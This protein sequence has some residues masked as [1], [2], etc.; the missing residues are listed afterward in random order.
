MCWTINLVSLLVLLGSFTTERVLSSLALTRSN[1]RNAGSAGMLQ[2][3]CTTFNTQR[4]HGWVEK[5]MKQKYSAG[6][7][8]E[9]M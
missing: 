4:M 5:A 1:G 3:Q 6:A 9:K 8:L 7:C 2:Q